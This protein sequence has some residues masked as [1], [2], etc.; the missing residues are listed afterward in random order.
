MRH[1]VLPVIALAL[2][3]LATG[4]GALAGPAFASRVP[5][6]LNNPAFCPAPSN[7]RPSCYNVIEPKTWY[8]TGDGSAGLYD[9]HWTYWGAQQAR[10]TGML[11]I[12]YGDWQKPPLYGWHKFPVYV[13]AVTPVTWQGH[14]VYANIY[15]SPVHSTAATAQAFQTAS[16]LGV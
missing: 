5:A 15:T 4:V 10:G 1:R 16:D 7:V 11:S 14:Y 2:G 13:T 6:L 9:L 12:R 8:W 3:T